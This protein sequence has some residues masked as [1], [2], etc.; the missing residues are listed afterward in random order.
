MSRRGLLGSG[1]MN[2]THTLRRSAGLAA[3]FATTAALASACAGSQEEP[4]PQYAQQPYP[5]QQGYPQQQPGYAQP[6]PGYAQPQAG[7]PAAAPAST[8]PPPSILATPCSADGQCIAARCNVA[9][10]KCF[11]P[12]GSSADCQAGFHCLG[13]GTATAFCAPGAG[14]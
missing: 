2:V 5:Q 7:Y 12:C 14:P 13:A 9:V 6:Q 3:L 10:G 1:V 11:L 4:P 8:A